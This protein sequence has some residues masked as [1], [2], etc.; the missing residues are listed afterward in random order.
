MVLVINLE[1]FCHYGETL[2]ETVDVLISIGYGIVLDFRQPQLSL[3]PSHSF[4]LSLSPSHSFSLS[5][6]LSLP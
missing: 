1:R 3:P 5:P 6:S 2:F 4:S